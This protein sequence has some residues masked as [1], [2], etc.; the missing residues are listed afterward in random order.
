MAPTRLFA[1]PLE[2]Q[3]AALDHNAQEN[4]QTQVSQHSYRLSPKYSLLKRPTRARL[5][6]PDQDGVLVLQR[7][8]ALSAAAT[9]PDDDPHS[10]KLRTSSSLNLYRPHGPSRD[11]RRS[12]AD[13]MGGGDFIGAHPKGIELLNPVDKTWG[14]T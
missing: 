12:E 3:E 7:H 1:D 11:G 2:H 10:D 8:H 9:Q 13:T 14:N 6:H 5:G 4:E